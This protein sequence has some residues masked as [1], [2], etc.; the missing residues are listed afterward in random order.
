[1]V[2]LELSGLTTPPIYK[3]LCV[4]FAL[5]VFQVVT[6]FLHDFVVVKHMLKLFKEGLG[7][8]EDIEHNYI[9]NKGVSTLL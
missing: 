8:G 9:W 4:F 1:M 2:L 6:I 5:S 3:S 7:W